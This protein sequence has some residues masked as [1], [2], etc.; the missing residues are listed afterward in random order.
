VQNEEKKWKKN[1]K[2]VGDMEGVF[3]GSMHE[4]A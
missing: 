4:R 2:D 1:V 3:M